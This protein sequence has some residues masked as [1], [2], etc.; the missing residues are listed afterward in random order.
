VPMIIRL[1]GIGGHLAELI[2]DLREPAEDRTLIDRLNR[3][4]GNLREVTQA[5]DLDLAESLLEPVV[6]HFSETLD[7]VAAARPDLEPKCTDL[8]E[9]LQRF[10]EPAEPGELPGSF[11]G[12]NYDDDVPF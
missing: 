6:L 7:D 8:R 5:A 2:V 9:K 1:H 4:F 10:L 12:G 11:D 3:E